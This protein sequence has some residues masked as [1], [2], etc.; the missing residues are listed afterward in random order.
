M[1]EQK[2]KTLLKYFSMFG[3]FYEILFGILMIFFIVPLLNLLGGNITQPEFPIFHQTGGLLAIIIGLILLFSSF[4]VEKF[5]LNIVI[6]TGL[7]FA[8]QVVIVLNMFLIPEIAI[9]LLLFGLIDLIFAIIT[10]CLMK[11][12]NLSFNIVK[13]LK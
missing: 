2:A 13:M 6:I 4:N 8:I 10:I 3:G 7:R 12:S 5:I 9:G 11:I 1:N